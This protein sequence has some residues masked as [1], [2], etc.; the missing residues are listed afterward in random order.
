MAS[1]ESWLELRGRGR[2]FALGIVIDDLEQIGSR[3]QRESLRVFFN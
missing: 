2:D 3:R 1:F